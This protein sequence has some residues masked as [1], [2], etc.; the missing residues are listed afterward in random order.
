[1]FRG[2]FE[3]IAPQSLGK[4]GIIPVLALFFCLS[5][6]EIWLTHLHKNYIFEISKD[7]AIISQRLVFLA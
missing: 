6:P 5:F 4:S 7:R 2:Q 1:M 3:K